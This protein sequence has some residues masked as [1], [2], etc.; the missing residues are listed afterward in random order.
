VSG[1]FFVVSTGIFL[2]VSTG[3]IVVSTAVL[4]VVPD[5]FFVELQEVATIVKHPAIARLK[6]N[7]FI[8]LILVYV[9]HNQQGLCVKVL[10]NLKLMSENIKKASLFYEKSLLKN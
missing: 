2:V 7:F 5:I 6:I 3:L 4:S 9:L 8:G 1:S 10:N